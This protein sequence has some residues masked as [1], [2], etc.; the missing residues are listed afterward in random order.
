M[1][2][3]RE[4]YT[5]RRKE[6]EQAGGEWRRWRRWRRKHERDGGVGRRE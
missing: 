4:K 1:T 5:K 3:E 6:S 2:T